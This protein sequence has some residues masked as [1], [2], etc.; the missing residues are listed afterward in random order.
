MPEVFCR[1][2]CVTDDG[3]VV[4]TEDWDYVY[5]RCEGH[6]LPIKGFATVVAA[7]TEED[8]KPAT[9]TFVTVAGKEESYAY[10]LDNPQ[11]IRLADPAA[12]EPTFG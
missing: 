5:I 11:S 7:F 10:I 1:V 8:L 6:D 3:F 4:W 2:E 12:G 9:G